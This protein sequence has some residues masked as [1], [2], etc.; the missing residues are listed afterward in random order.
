MRR[1]ATR[2]TRAHTHT[3]THTVMES[4]FKYMYLH[5]ECWHT[6]SMV[7]I[8]FE[9]TLTC[10]RTNTPPPHTEALLQWMQ[11]LTH[12]GV[13]QVDA[14]QAL[15]AVDSALDSAQGWFTVG[16]SLSFIQQREVFWV[17]DVTVDLGIVTTKVTDRVCLECGAN[18][19]SIKKISL[20]K[21][22]ERGL[23]C[24]HCWPVFVFVVFGEDP[25]IETQ[26]KERNTLNFITKINDKKRW[27]LRHL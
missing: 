24:L 17:G 25:E 26:E 3:H 18:L 11:S 7:A 13:Q 23:K 15:A 5:T 27:K 16:R 1:D 22:S 20:V 6:T 21:W 14:V 2:R 12:I 8:S 19:I 10:M 4:L 9:Y